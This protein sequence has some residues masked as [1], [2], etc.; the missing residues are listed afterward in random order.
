M[1][2]TTLL[3]AVALI[4]ASTSA[5]AA[6]FSF[7]GNLANDDEV[8]F[9]NFTVSS[10]STVTLRTWSYA[11]GTNAAGNLI[12]SGGFDPILA[13]F[14]S[15]GTLIGQNDD[16]QDGVVPADPTTS[17]RFDT[18]LQTS[19][20]AGSYTV[21]VSQFANFAIGPTLADGF[22]GS[23]TTNFRDATGALRTSAWA[24]DVLNVDQA[25]LPPTNGVPDSGSSVMLALLA[26]GS[27]AAL[28]HARR[29]A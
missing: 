15:S 9:F 29:L 23:N 27:L 8:Q 3:G 20:A 4:F 1:K 6:N 13:L 24:F 7:T 26:A 10:Q 19:L 21:A 25:T 16:D 5:F 28:R 18:Y 2:H 14:N 17:A 12:G 22:S 11:G